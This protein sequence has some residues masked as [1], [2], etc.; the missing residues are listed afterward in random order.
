MN[1]RSWIL[2]LAVTACLAAP[3]ARAAGFATGTCELRTNSFFTH[4]SASFDGQHVLSIT[5]ADLELGV[6]VFASRYLEPEAAFAIV[7]Q[8]VDIEGLG[9]DSN[10]A[11]AFSGGLRVNFPASGEVLPFVGAG[12]GVQSNGSGSETS[13]I[14]PY[15]T[16]GM[17]I[18]VRGSAAVE[19]A[20]K[21]EH[22][23]NYLGGKDLDGSVFGATIGLSLFIG[24]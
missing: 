12:V 7:H 2:P 18:L 14:A 8:S 6:G 21:Y 3:P 23:T 11:S 10:T 4:G 19:F 20:A 17:R 5:Q 9:S 13:I 22:V 1:R 24:R 15:A 16:G